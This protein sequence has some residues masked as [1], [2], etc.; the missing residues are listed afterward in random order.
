MAKPDS[1]KDDAD[2][3]GTDDGDDK[4]TDKKDDAGRAGGNEQLKKDLARERRDRQALQTQLDEVNKKLDAHEK[5]KLSD[6]EKLAAERD[7]IKAELDKTRAEVLRMTVASEKG[8]TAAQAKRLVGSTKEELEADAEELLETFGGGKSAEDDD[9]D[10]DSSG[11]PSSR[12]KE[13]FRGGGKPDA[14]PEETDERAL[15]S[16]HPRI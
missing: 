3:T 14:E 10:D 2:D 13:K 11:P 9:G 4:G 6:T 5:A 1:A 15:A 16:R 12:P 7:E 8:L